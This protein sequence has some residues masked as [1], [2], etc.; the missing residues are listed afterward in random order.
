MKAFTLSFLNMSY[1]TKIHGGE[2]L[3]WKKWKQ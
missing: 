1:C 2:T 3:S